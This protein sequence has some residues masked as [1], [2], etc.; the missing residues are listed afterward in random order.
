MKPV[1]YTEEDVLFKLIIV[2]LKFQI[3]ANYYIRS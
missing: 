3:K 1:V 2:A